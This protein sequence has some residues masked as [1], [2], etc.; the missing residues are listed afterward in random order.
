[1]RV[2]GTEVLLK[3]GFGGEALLFENRMTIGLSLVAL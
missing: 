3:G 1:M 2:L